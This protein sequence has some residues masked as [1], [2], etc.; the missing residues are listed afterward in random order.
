MFNKLQLA[1]D[2]RW[3]LSFTCWV[4]EH[5]IDCERAPLTLKK[6]Q[7]PLQAEKPL[8]QHFRGDGRGGGG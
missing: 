6:I 4:G 7:L 5:G 1:Q 8:F 2:W 3:W